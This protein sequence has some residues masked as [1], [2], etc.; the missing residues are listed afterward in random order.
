MR[1]L[2]AIILCCIFIL[3]L[4]SC[5]EE[6]ITFDEPSV[7]VSKNGIITQ[8]IVER[9]DKSYY[10]ANELQSEIEKAINDYCLNGG[11]K[12]D[13]SLSDVHTDNGNVFVT[14]VFSSYEADKKFQGEDVFFGT[15]NEAYDNGYSLDI[16]LLS[17]EDGSVIGKSELMEL[18]KNHILIL[19]TPGLVNT[20]NKIV[21]VS[22][23]VEVIDEKNVRILSD[24]SG[25]A[26]IV[27]K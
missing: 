22:P 27:T 9:F 19:S 20:Y 10:N 18:K 21:Y 24:S 6:Q 15:V 26:Y 5:K 1:K 16:S 2:L 7:R 3:S 17:V 13:V 25:L 14:L 4:C 12:D 23:N 8:T 11:G